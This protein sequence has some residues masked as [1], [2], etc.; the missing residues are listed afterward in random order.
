MAARDAVALER[1]RIARELHDVVA[2]AMSVMV[3]QAGAARAV[4]ERDPG[5]AARALA[6][7]EETGRTGWPRCAG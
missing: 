6:A 2:H 1:G 5:E 3:V 4:V 7:I